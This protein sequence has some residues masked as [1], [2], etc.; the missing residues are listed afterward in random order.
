MT[1]AIGTHEAGYVP[2]VISLDE[3]KRAPLSKF[4]SNP[5]A[6]YEVVVDDDGTI[7][8]TPGRFVADYELRLHSTRPDLVESINREMAKG[9]GSAV[10]RSAFRSAEPT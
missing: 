4:I 2:A 7:T 5:A 8:L 9:R 1:S 10:R 6:A 3:R